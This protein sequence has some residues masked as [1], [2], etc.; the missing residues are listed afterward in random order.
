MLK[1]KIT[2]FMSVSTSKKK[3]TQ[4]IYLQN[5][6]VIENNIQFFKLL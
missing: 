3:S 5:E 4:D 6:Y 2:A 1:I